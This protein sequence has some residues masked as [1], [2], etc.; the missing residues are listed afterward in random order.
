MSNSKGNAAGFE[1]GDTMKRKLKAMQKVNEQVLDYIGMLQEQ[2]GDMEEKVE[3]FIGAADKVISTA[4]IQP[5]YNRVLYSQ[6]KSYDWSR[7]VEQ[8]EL[9]SSYYKAK[10]EVLQCEINV[11]KTEK[12]LEAVSKVLIDEVK[13]T[14]T[15]FEEP[16]EEEH[17][18]GSPS[19]RMPPLRG[20]EDPGMTRLLNLSIK[21]QNFF[22]SRVKQEASHTA[23]S[24]EEEKESL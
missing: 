22:A 2:K 1:P 14:L 16:I 15:E 4:A 6:M 19:F 8:K 3:S 13:A 7:S 24:G 12:Q 9:V 17:L 20:F 11:L 10:G 23:Q 18:W 21:N 5:N